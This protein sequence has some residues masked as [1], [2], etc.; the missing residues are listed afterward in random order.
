MMAPPPKDAELRGLLIIGASASAHPAPLQPLPTLAG[1]PPSATWA[2]TWVQPARPLPPNR[3][4]NADPPQPLEQPSTE[5]SI[6]PQQ[7]EAHPP[8]IASS[9]AAAKP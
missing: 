5:P 8:L 7:G 9:P 4:S 3:V 2:P 1:L 6:G